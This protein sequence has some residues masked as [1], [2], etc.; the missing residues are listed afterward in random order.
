MRCRNILHRHLL[1]AAPH[2]CYSN[3][4]T[5]RRQTRDRS[6]NRGEESGLVQGESQKVLHQPVPKQLSI[7][8]VRVGCFVRFKRAMLS[9]ARGIEPIL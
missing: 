8:A 5:P 1:P 2:F 6:K 3:G 9:P 7:V 4:G